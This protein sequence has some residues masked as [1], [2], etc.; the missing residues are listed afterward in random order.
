MLQPREQL[1][2]GSGTIHLLPCSSIPFDLPDEILGIMDTQQK[3]SFHL[4]FTHGRDWQKTRNREI[5]NITSLV[6]DGKKVKTQGWKWTQAALLDGGGVEVTEE[7][8]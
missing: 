4:E 1:A 2:E 6:S 8:I 5:Y 7:G 3:S